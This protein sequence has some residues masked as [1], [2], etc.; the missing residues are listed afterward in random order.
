MTAILA[1]SR[2][3][4]SCTSL[5]MLLSPAPMVYKIHKD[6]H[7]GVLSIVPLVAVL[8]NSHMWYN[9]ARLFKIRICFNC[10]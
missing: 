7:S 4:A 8:V 10:V 9:T 1:I 6:Q 2:V 5:F 3:F